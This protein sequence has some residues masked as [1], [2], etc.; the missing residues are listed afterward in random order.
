MDSHDDAW[1]NHVL[2]Y[3]ENSSRNGGAIVKKRDELNNL[4]DVIARTFVYQ[5]FRRMRGHMYYLSSLEELLQ[6]GTP[7][8]YG[9]SGINPY[10][11]FYAGCNEKRQKMF[12][13]NYRRNPCWRLGSDEPSHLPVLEIK[14]AINNLLPTEEENK[15]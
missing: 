14:A 9:W 13:F 15:C 4:Y 12:N 11:H 1:A 8:G 3:G 7:H 6:S 10:F 2:R 5:D